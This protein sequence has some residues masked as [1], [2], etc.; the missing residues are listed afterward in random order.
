R[1]RVRGQQH[2]AERYGQAVR[3]KAQFLRELVGDLR[4]VLA[5]AGHRLTSPPGDR[6]E[7]TGQ[8]RAA[9]EGAPAFGSSRSAVQADTAHL[10]SLAGFPP[11]RA[12]GGT[13]SPFMRKESG[14]SVEPSPIVTP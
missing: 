5:D 10:T 7:R 4:L 8:K 2:G 12:C 14:A 13:S 11:H 9:P 6:G 1:L 3:H